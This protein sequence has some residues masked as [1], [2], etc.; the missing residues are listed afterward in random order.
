MYN[1]MWATRVSKRARKLFDPSIVP[2]AQEIDF[3]ELLT[4]IMGSGPSKRQKK[5]PLGIGS[6]SNLYTID[7]NIYFQDDID[8]DTV[9]ELNR[10]MREMR[11]RL[12]QMSRDFN[13]DPPPIKLHLTTNG[14]L[15]HAALSAIDCINEMDGVE[16]HTIVDGYVASAGT[17]ISVCGDKRFI[18][19]NAVM[20]IHELRSEMWGKMS[21]ME[22]EMK[23][24]KKMSEAIRDIYLQNTKLKRADLSRIL[25]KD[26][27][28]ESHECLEKGLVDEII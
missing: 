24:L 20:L 16:V 11:S 10:E 15:V 17:L 27:N 8:Y 14:G 13:I 9:S 3:G 6:S 22:D 21:D 5:S 23:N 25:K 26:I 19:R 4:S 7:N 2:G 12:L 28:W 1:N 18:K